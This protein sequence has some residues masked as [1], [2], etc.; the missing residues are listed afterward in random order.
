MNEIEDIL[1]LA[2]RPIIAVANTFHEKSKTSPDALPHSK[3]LIDALGLTSQAIFKINMLR[4]SF[5]NVF[6]SFSAVP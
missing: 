3:Q 5:I 2:L 4:V 6:I 1:L